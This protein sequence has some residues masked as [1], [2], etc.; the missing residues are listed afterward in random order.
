MASEVQHRYVAVIL[1]AGSAC[2]LIGARNGAAALGLPHTRIYV[3]MTGMDTCRWNLVR[4]LVVLQTTCIVLLNV[5]IEAMVSCYRSANGTKPGSAAVARPGHADRGRTHHG[6][7]WV[8]AHRLLT[9]PR[10]S[11]GVL[12]GRRQL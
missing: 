1:E 2:G 5:G 4:Q 9:S 10:N 3:R 6:N 7:R 8:A 11:P 12:L